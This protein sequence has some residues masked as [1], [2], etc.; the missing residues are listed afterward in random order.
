MTR[1]QMIDQAV[2]RS[3]PRHALERFYASDIAYGW[4]DKIRNEFQ[5]LMTRE[6]LAAHSRE[7]GMEMA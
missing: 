6:A 1:E 7:L 3:V 5:R 4:Q 2:R